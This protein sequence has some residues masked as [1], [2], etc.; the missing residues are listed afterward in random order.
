MTEG[1]DLSLPA[2]PARRWKTVLGLVLTAGVLSYAFISRMSADPSLQ[3]M[4]PR[5]DA[6]AAAM[7]HVLNNFS[8]ADDLLVLA[9]LPDPLDK[10]RQHDLTDFAA[11]LE[12]SIH[13]SPEASQLVEA[14]AYRPDAESRAFIAGNVVPA[15]IYY[16]SDEKYAAAKQRLTKDEMRRQLRQD[17]A[18][19][20]APGPAAGAL[21]SVFLKDPLRLHE[22]LVDELN[23][24]KP[25][26]FG[27]SSDGFFS[28]DGRSLL[29]RVIGKRSLSD[30]AYARQ[31][32]D[33]ITTLA[34]RV[35]ESVQVDISGGYAIASTSERAIRGDMIVSVVSSVVLLQL[36]FVL[37][38][39]RPIRYFILAFLPVALGLL[40][41][42][43]VR[44]A[45]S[46][47]I[48]PAAAVV[49]AVLAGMGIDYTVLYLPHYH[50]A[51]DARLSTVAAVGRTTR[52]LASPLLA[53]C[54]TSVIGFLAVGWSSVPAL[55]DFSLVGSLGLIGSLLAA[56]VILPA[57]LASN[58]RGPASGA[59]P[60]V[61]LEPL[62]GWVTRH[63]RQV[64]WG[65]AGFL[66]SLVIVVAAVPGPLLAMESD[67]TVMHPRPNKPLDAEAKIA[68][69]MGTDPG[70][71]AVFL[72]ADTDDQLIQ[73]AYDVQRRLSDAA[74]KQAGVVDVYGL[75]TLL[76]DPRVVA[77][78]RGQVSAGETDRILADFRSAVSET[79]FDPAAFSGYETFLR[80][81]LDGPATPTIADLHRS[82]RLAET[83]LGRVPGEAMT[84][85]FFADPLD[86]RARRV[87]AVEAI[88]HAL[89]G[90]PGVTLTGLGVIGLDTETAIQHD[91][92]RLLAAAVGL[93]VVYLLI[94]F[95]RISSV[96][97]SLIPAAVSLLCLTAVVR[98]T[99]M[100]LN[101]VNLVALPLLIGID[102][103]YGIYLVSL[104]RPRVPIA[105][106]EAR[107]RVTTSVY[108]VMISAAANVLGFGS[109]VTTSVPAIRSLGWAVGVGVLACFAA[110]IFLLVPLLIREAGE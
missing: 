14:F 43:G 10:A 73:L 58:D 11:R 87:A 3:N 57:L 17:E 7:V 94:H 8:A 76:P 56:V 80:Y 100:K 1:G 71:M 84:Q 13:D 99:G 102:V 20:S 9:T 33:V 92:P 63:R 24:R 4:F 25:A 40:Y 66:T 34:D 37:A 93:N 44:G 52:Q 36:L 16:L 6:S 88:R 74:V 22:F 83:L 70:A 5:G 38:Y 35:K 54:L 72:K 51:R 50:T 77:N 106:A 64:L 69:R 60:R 79:S 105:G 98:V 78:R 81:T 104:A 49:G 107:R 96:L 28:P 89:A 46:S 59:R 85:I 48:S 95:R 15:G 90:L 101:L 47:T 29:I 39:R 18:M 12:K 82:P 26:G 23:A 62:L 68:K 110:T 42:F 108:S 103:D 2:L 41:G 55:K 109:L 86:T 75:S 67:L 61:R 53:A 31:L 45:I 97:L 91:L 27:D 32:T 30:L 19:L 21:A 65:W